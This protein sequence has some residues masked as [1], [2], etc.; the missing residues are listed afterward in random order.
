VA[1]DKV[2]ALPWWVLILIGMFGIPLVLR[3]VRSA[4]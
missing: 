4:V 1:L 2:K 3:M